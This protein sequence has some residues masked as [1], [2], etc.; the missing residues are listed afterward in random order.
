MNSISLAFCC[1][2]Q[3]LLWSCNFL[4]FGC[5]SKSGTA[6]WFGDFPRRWSWCQTPRQSVPLK[7]HQ[8]NRKMALQLCKW[9]I[10]REMTSWYLIY[11]L[12]LT[13]LLFSGS[14]RRVG[15]LLSE[16][17][18]QELMHEATFAWPGV[19]HVTHVDTLEGPLL[20]QRLLGLHQ[21]HR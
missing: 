4:H 8:K 20:S 9:E 16:L 13:V 15:R 11:L 14:S 2:N 21:H 5:G 19:V 18:L 1:T 6:A 12:G 3:G 10:W 17:P 7:T